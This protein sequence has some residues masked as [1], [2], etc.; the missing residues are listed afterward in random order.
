[1]AFRIT[2][3]MENQAPSDCLTEEHGLSLLVEGENCRIL[4]DTGA[5][6][7]FLKN[8]AQ[9]GETLEP[10]DALVLSHGHYDHTGGVAAL[11][12]GQAC[13]GS[14]YLGRNFF[15]PRYSR[16]EDGLKEIGAAFE[17]EAV[18]AAG[19]SC[20]EVG[21]EP[22]ALAPGVWAVSGFT[23]TEEMEGPSPT[24]MRSADGVL[25]EDRFQDEVV[26]VLETAVL[27]VF[28][29]VF[30]VLYM[31]VREYVCLRVYA[32]ARCFLLS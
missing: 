11:L 9:L 3:L 29:A 22:I 14:V 30:L 21:D 7:M 5:S 24:M 19:I 13:P 26:L 2:T 16:K 6:P 27:T 20:V 12:I 28:L 4:Y 25:E 1:M 10:L 8:A 32:C 17:R 31:H 18:S 15:G 23:S